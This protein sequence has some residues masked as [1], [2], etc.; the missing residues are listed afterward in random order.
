MPEIVELALKTV[1]K[2]PYTRRSGSLAARCGFPVS[3]RPARVVLS[4]RHLLASEE[5]RMQSIF[6]ARG[7]YGVHGN[8]KRASERYSGYQPTP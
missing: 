7:C 2:A 8:A 6:G 3:V 4:K 1:A 5:K